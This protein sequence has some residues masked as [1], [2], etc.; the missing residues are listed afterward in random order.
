M[1]CVEQEIK[2]ETRNGFTEE[3]KLR[4]NIL[5]HKAVSIYYNEFDIVKLADN[6]D[7]V[8]DR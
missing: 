8:V 4:A 5:A 6:Y 2:E 3:M 7:N 1:K